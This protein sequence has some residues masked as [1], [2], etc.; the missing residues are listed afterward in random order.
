VN[1]AIGVLVLVALVLSSSK[2]FADT[3]NVVGPVTNPAVGDTFAVDVDV[4][5]ITD[6]YA[7]Q[8]DL[9]FD[10]TLLSAV[11]VVEGGFL[12]SGGATFFIPGSIDSV[13]GTVAATADTLIGAIPGVTGDGTLAEFEFTALAPGTSALSFANEILLDSS[14]NDITANTTFQNGSVTIGS[15]SSVPEP[16]TLVLLCTVFI[17][18]GM[19][20]FF[21]RQSA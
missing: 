4:T 5:G 12:P 9:S 11:S 14:L 6:L 2:I 7:F 20:R 18:G 1:K 21:R 15:V 13:G 17:L 10:P 19:L 3:I 16:N 8:F